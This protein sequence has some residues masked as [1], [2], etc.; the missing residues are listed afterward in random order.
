M[1]G[2]TGFVLLV[3]S[4]V[5]RVRFREPT[6][7]AE[8]LDCVISSREEVYLL[9]IEYWKELFEAVEFIAIVAEYSGVC[10]GMN[11]SLT[12]GCK[13]ERGF[14]LSRL[15]GRMHGLGVRAKARV[16]KMPRGVSLSCNTRG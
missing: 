5:L 9:E 13:G 10:P 3:V 14:S 11:A 4:F 15:S 1:Y 16:E 12:G 2:S 8:N 7:R 6:L